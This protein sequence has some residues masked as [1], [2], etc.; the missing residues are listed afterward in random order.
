VLYLMF[1]VVLQN[2]DRRSFFE[3]H[4]AIFSMD[5]MEWREIH[6]NGLCR[7]ELSLNPY[8]MQVTPDNRLSLLVPRFAISDNF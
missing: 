4:L 7:G 1:I 2:E 3:N 6:L 5:K 8:R